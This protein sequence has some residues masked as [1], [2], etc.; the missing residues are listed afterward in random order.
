MKKTIFSL[1]LVVSLVMMFTVT[2]VSAKEYYYTNDNGVSLTKEEYDFLSELYWDGYQERMTQEQYEKFIE[3]DLINEEIVS[4]EAYDVDF[5][6]R[7]TEHTTSSKK[8]K[9]SRVCTS[10][11]TV[12]ISLTWLVNPS[13]RSWDVIG[14]RFSG[15]S[16]LYTPI[17]QY[18]DSSTSFYSSNYKTASN[19]V[20]NSLDLADGSNITIYQEMD[21]TSGGTVYASYQHAVS[22]TTL[23]VSKDYSFSIS[24]YG[25][26]FLFGTAGRSIYDGMNGVSVNL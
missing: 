20:G 25:D 8:I 1:F 18:M 12:V 5:I 6:T 21:V 11:C 19:G 7:G 26:V 23:A 3:K 24:G 10:D 13:T 4:D 9:I 17:T 22:N 15:V 14:A 2:N 16:L